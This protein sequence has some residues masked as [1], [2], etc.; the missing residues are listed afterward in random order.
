MFISGLLHKEMAGPASGKD[1][2]ALL[3]DLTEATK[4]VL[5]DAELIAMTSGAVLGQKL[6]A[7]KAKTDT[8]PNRA[9]YAL[10][11]AMVAFDKAS[12]AADAVVIGTYFSTIV[13]MVQVGVLSY[14]LEKLARVSRRNVAL[15]EL[16]KSPKLFL[17]V[18]RC[19]RY[20][21]GS[22]VE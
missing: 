14:S 3:A 16:E 5:S 6:E 1:L 19:A 21:P 9:V 13:N 11:K 2:S 17:Q 18:F 4:N 10:D 8:I 12:D 15:A 22:V 7:I 20:R